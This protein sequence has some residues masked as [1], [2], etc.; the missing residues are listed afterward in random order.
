MCSS[1]EE[2]ER[3]EE[4]SAVSFACVT[5]ADR[6]VVSSLQTWLRSGVSSSSLTFGRGLGAR[7]ELAVL[8][9]WSRAVVSWGGRIYNKEVAYF[10]S[11][12][13]SDEIGELLRSQANSQHVCPDRGFCSA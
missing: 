12:L 7:G 10:S 5:V 8:M 9:P 4:V 1:W 13:G 3:S 6:V 2:H 11:G